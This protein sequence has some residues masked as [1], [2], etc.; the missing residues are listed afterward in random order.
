VDKSGNPSPQVTVDSPGPG[1]AT[2]Y[3][4]S[5]PLAYSKTTIPKASGFSIRIDLFVSLPNCDMSSDDKYVMPNFVKTFTDPA[6]RPRLELAVLNGVR[7]EYTHP[8]FIGDDLV[9]HTAENSPWGN[10]DVDVAGGITLGIAD[11]SGPVQGV[12]R[13]ATVQRTHDHN[14]HTE[15]VDVTFV[16]PYRELKAGDG[17]YTITLRVQND[18]AT[19]VATGVAQFEVG[20]D[21]RVTKCGGLTTVAGASDQGCVDEYQGRDGASRPAPAKAS[22]GLELAGLLGSLGAVAARLWRRKA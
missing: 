6:H 11:G 7:I 17:T 9:V 5:I 13:A 4:F 12:Y 8:Q 20:K 19:A 16:W 1:K 22:P 2:V 14:H 10:Y 21:L 3:G 15:A 18:Q